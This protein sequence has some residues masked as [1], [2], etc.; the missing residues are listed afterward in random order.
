MV[1]VTNRLPTSCNIWVQGWEVCPCW[2]IFMLFYIYLTLNISCVYCTFMK[3]A[4]HVQ[5]LLS[6]MFYWYLSTVLFLGIMEIM[7]TGP[8]FCT[9]LH[10]TQLHFLNTKIFSHYTSP[11]QCLQVQITSPAFIKFKMPFSVKIQLSTVH[12]VYLLSLLVW[13]FVICHTSPKLRKGIFYQNLLINE[14]HPSE[15]PGTAS[16]LLGMWENE[17]I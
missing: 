16:T 13:H 3:S 7:D 9:G 2:S 14:S 1:L 4:V 6:N 12:N 17:W 10:W 11:V 8:V 5:L 15:Y